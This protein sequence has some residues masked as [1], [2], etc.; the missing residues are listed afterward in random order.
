M[1]LHLPQ[2]QARNQ[3]REAKSTVVL[4]WN[5]FSDIF[6]RLE[7]FSASADDV[8]AHIAP[9]SRV[10]FSAVNLCMLET[11]IL[12]CGCMTRNFLSEIYC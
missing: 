8:L 5:Y 7:Y 6:D 10:I 12:S 3:V 9:L 11:E 4:G 1:M 2:N